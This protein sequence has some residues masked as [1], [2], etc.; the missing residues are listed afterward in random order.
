MRGKTMA[1]TK[2]SSNNSGG[3]WWLTDQNWKDLEA[4]GWKVDWVKD[5]PLYQRWGAKDRWL[6]ALAT[7]ASCNLPEPEAIAQ[8]ERIT[9]QNSEAGGCNCCGEPHYFS[10]EPDE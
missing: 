3:N 10:E 2:Y 9:G 4:A 6:G 5:E 7:T 8:F 1:R